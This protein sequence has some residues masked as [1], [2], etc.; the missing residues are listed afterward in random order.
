[1]FPT[2]DVTPDQ[3]QVGDRVRPFD[4]FAS[5]VTVVDIRRT[6]CAPTRQ[7]PYPVTRVDLGVKL[8]WASTV[9]DVRVYGDQ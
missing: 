7:R 9:W 5:E 6:A 8:D 4:R 3:L 1:M 2:A